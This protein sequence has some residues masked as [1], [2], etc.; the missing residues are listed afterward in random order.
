[1]AQSI[2]VSGCE[3]KIK[4]VD[5]VV[6]GSGAAGW[7][8]ACRLREAGVETALVTEGVNVGTSRNTGSDKQT[9]YKLTLAGGEADAV[10]D[11]AR[12]LFEGQCVDWSHALAEAALSPRCFFKLVELG[13]P[14]PHN[15]SGEYVGYKTDH[16]PRRRA[17]S[18]GPYTSKMMTEQWE[19]E[20]RR[21]GVP[22]YDKL[23]LI[24]IITR[25]PA[26]CG[27][28]CLNLAETG[29]ADR[30][31]AFNCRN[32][33]LATGGPAGIYA[34]LAYPPGQHGATGVAFAAGAGG[35]NLTEWQYGLA[36]LRPRWNVSGSYMQALPRFISQGPEGEREFLRDAFPDRNERLSRIFLKG[37]QWPFDVRKVEGSSAIDLLVYQE[38]VLKGRRVFL[39]F[40]QNPQGMDVEFDGLVPEARDYL[41]RAG[42]DFGLPIQRLLRM[43]AP[44]VEFYRSRGVDLCREPLEVALCAQHNNGGLAVDPWYETNLAG[45]F[46]V[47]EAAAT[48]G[49]YRPGGSAL[50]AGQA[51]ALRAALRIAARGERGPVPYEVFLAEAEEA[52][53]QAIARGQGAL[54]QASTVEAARGQAARRMS[55]CAGPIR[56]PARLRA[57]LADTEADLKN[58][59]A[60]AQVDTPKKLGQV[61]RLWDQLVAQAVYL[62]AMVNYADKGGGS[63]GSA[64]YTDPAGALPQGA[65][66]LPE[67]FRH[68]QD[69]GALARRIQEVTL[70]PRAGGCAARWRDVEPPPEVAAEDFFEN[71][72]RRYRES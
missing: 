60:L 47:G 32:L 52:V 34:D 9:Y 14:F 68:R 17:T 22:V 71:V 65:G 10:W 3:I 8:A 43:N 12:T 26:V 50:N 54:G 51:G 41:R 39:D 36:S 70:N 11:M 40:T 29:P 61:Y 7:A 66:A 15:E 56:D 46:A 4:G 42:A 1:M 44:A 37:Y 48:H 13:V 31:L 18:A 67:I 30:Y 19:G 35:R 49:V 55:A 16:D 45:L 64:L 33:V 23:Q 69:A 27:L 58:F 28:L 5:T 63:R 62:Y 25:G 21:L 72:W 57:A 2:Q 38:V 59:A 53:P 24:Q 20:A 6:V